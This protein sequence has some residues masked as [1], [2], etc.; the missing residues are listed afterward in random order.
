MSSETSLTFYNT[1]T[2]RR[3]TFIPRS[4]QAVRLF[5]CGPSVYRRQHLGNYRTFLFED[6]LQRYLEYR[7]YPVERAINFTDVEDKAVEEAKAEGVTLEE[8][9]RPVIDE[10][11][12]TAAQLG[13]RLPAGEIPRATTSVE[14][15]VDII[16][17]LIARGHAYWHRGNVYYDP[18]TLPGFGT[19]F[20]LDMSKWPKKRYRFSRDTYEGLRWNR[21]DFILWHGTREDDPFSWQTRL[22]RGRP[23]WN[24]QDPA[25][26]AKTLGYELDIHCGGIDNVYRHHDYNRAVMEG[27]SGSE[28]CHYWLHG[29]H[30]ILNGKK[31][32]KSLGNVLYPGDLFD[33]GYSPE[34]VRF[35]LIYGHY[36]SQLNMT[37]TLLRRTGELLDDMT[38]T[39]KIA[40]QPAEPKMGTAEAQRPRSLRPEA[41]SR[42]TDRVIE[43]LPQLFKLQM[44]NDLNV[45]AAVDDLQGIL[46]DLRRRGE[47]YGRTAE[48][49]TR[50][51]RYLG[52]IDGVLGVLFPPG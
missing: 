17:R 42:R 47:L 4:S 34:H 48:Q 12:D 15:A 49:A 8:L 9:T 45:K 44:D 35:T 36:R 3:E 38:R 33:R 51:R 37:D 31:M 29:E 52:E 43:E 18:L 1:L 13:I 10:F 26:I 23:A 5:T 24:V 40:T 41:E 50:I 21:G 39:A 27:V 19:I 46:E 6:L 11:L 28:F 16:E 32:S 7:G 20:G 30:L 14:H 2:K 22:G 25:M